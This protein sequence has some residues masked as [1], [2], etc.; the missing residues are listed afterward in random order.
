MF[1]S[2]FDFVVLFFKNKITLY[3]Y[4]VSLLLFIFCIFM[5]SLCLVF[6]CFSISFFKKLL[7]L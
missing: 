2:N 3:F 4:R 5:L 6:V 7:L 1:G